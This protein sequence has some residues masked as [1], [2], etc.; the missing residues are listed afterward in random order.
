MKKRLS[1]RLERQL[2]LFYALLIVKDKLTYIEYKTILKDNNLN[3]LLDEVTLS[4]HCTFI[5]KNYYRPLP[6]YYENDFPDIVSFLQTRIIPK[7]K[8]N[9]L[10]K[11]INNKVITQSPISITNALT[12]PT[13]W[14]KESEKTKTE[15]VLNNG[16]VINI[17][18][19]F[20]Q[21]RI[22]ERNQL[23]LI[24]H[25]LS[26]E[27]KQERYSKRS[28]QWHVNASFG[29]HSAQQYGVYFQNFIN[30]LFGC[31]TVPAKD[32]RGDIETPDGK[33]GEYKCSYSYIT[34][35]NYN[36][37]QLR[38]WQSIHFYIF[39]LMDMDMTTGAS[40]KLVFLTKNQLIYILNGVV[41]W[42]AAHGKSGRDMF[43]YGNEIRFTLDTGSKE[44]KY[45]VD[46]YAVSDSEL[47]N[48]LHNETIESL[49]KREIVIY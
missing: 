12:S 27:L 3:Y 5:S 26:P 24:S 32:G 45:L 49:E 30:D 8:K 38:M 11:A 21:Q 14:K 20:S 15:I 43:E 37:V 39:Q 36:I 33:F 18:D 9:S 47:H 2:Y 25:I 44:H 28:L 42:N 22:N 13:L 29:L 7:I 19:E 35:Y 31:E 6:E 48:I 10:R 46:N 17:N 23:K 1:L 40:Y 4:K 16:K 34:K 41:K